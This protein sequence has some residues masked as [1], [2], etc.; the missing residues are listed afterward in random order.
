MMMRMALRPIA[1]VAC[2]FH[3][4][5]RVGQPH[6]RPHHQHQGH[7]ADPFGGHESP[8]HQHVQNDAQLRH[9]VRRCQQKRQAGH[10]RRPAPEQRARDR[11]RGVGATGTR[12][13]RQR[14]QRHFA[15]PRPAQCRRHRTLRDHL[16]QNGRDH[17]SQH[18]A[19]ADMPEHRPRHLQGLR[20]MRQQIMHGGD[21]R[22]KPALAASDGNCCKLVTT[23][24]IK[25][26]PR[27]EDGLKPNHT[28]I[29]SIP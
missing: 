27:F 8:P 3:Q 4:R 7:R 10:Q 6:Q 25:H 23:A 24:S 5:R 17:E 2:G 13:P 9:Q 26:D 11:R 20:Q 15:W 14:C 28:F 29:T 1:M 19:P 22:P 16:L 21:P 18:Q 12:R